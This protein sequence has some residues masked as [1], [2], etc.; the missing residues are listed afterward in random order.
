MSPDRSARRDD[1]VL[2]PQ[3]TAHFDTFGF[4]F[5]PQLFSPAEMQ[6][7]RDAAEEIW[8]EDPQPVKDGDRRLTY[9]VERSEELSR[10]VEDDRIYR[11][12]EALLGPRFVW[13]GS[14]GNV[15]YYNQLRWHSDRKYFRRDEERWMGY[16]QM[17]AML[18]LDRVT[19][20]TGCMR[21]IPGSHRMPLHRALG[22]QE[23]DPDSM[24]FGVAGPEI[25]S[26]P[27]ESTPGDVILFNHC[28]WH[29][30][31]GGE[32]GRCYIALKFAARPAT[33]D[34]L[35]ALEQY[36]KTAFEPHPAFLDS[37]RPRLRN[38]VAELAQRRAKA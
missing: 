35:R 38:M 22:P 7:I 27:L 9:F 30:M 11:R 10:L 5:L 37:A 33:E 6:A 8:K 17:K 23:I 31:F 18:Y 24:P 28:I 25:P 21:V 20:H 1:D 12:V 26:V 13:V 19:R 34:H 29:A 3:E 4:L 16:A 32:R 15:T 36:T 2:S 14:E